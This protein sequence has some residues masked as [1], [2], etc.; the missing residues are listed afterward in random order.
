MLCRNPLHGSDH[1]GTH[2][3][4][5]GHEYLDIDGCCNLRDLLACLRAKF[6]PWPSNIV[7]RENK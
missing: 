3:A 6:L 5:E 1:I 2:R 7:E 4:G